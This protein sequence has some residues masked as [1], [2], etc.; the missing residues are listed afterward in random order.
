M[1]FRIVVVSLG[2]S[3]NDMLTYYL[4]QVQQQQQQQQQFQIIGG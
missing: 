2:D 4:L 1:C 3:H